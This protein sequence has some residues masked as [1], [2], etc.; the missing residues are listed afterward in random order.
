MTDADSRLTR[1]ALLRRAALSGLGAGLPWPRAA[2]AQPQTRQAPVVIFRRVPATAQFPA[3]G[4]TGPFGEVRVFNLAGAALPVFVSAADGSGVLGLDSSGR[5]TAVR[6]GTDATS[7]TFSSSSVRFGSAGPQP[8]TAD[9]VRRT[10]LE[11]SRDRRKARGAMLLRSALHTAFPVA[12]A[13]SSSAVHK[14]PAEAMAKGVHGHGVA[15]LGCTTRTVTDTVVAQVMQVVNVWKTAEQ[16]YQACVND[17]LTKD[18]CKTTLAVAGG[19]AAGLC[20]AA[21]CGAKSFVDMVTATTE[22]VTTVAE[23]VT[24]EVVTCVAPRPGEWPNPWTLIDHPIQVGLAQA[25]PPPAGGARPAAAPSAKDIEGALKLLP[26]IAGFL[27]PFGTCFFQGHWSLAQLNTPLNIG[28]TGVTLPYGVKCG[29]TAKC[30]SDLSAENVWKAALPSWG[31]A[32]SV[33]ATLS[34]DFATFATPLGI[35]AIPAVAA[36]AASVP[37]AV[38]AA[39]AIILAFVLLA[40]IYGTAISAQLFFQQHFTNNFADGVVYIEHPTFALALIKLATIG[41][42]PAELFPPIVTG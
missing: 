36:I 6:Y 31:A 21:I 28:G 42:A 23:E 29:L 22:V 35:T 30:A 7:I 11:I 38:T 17:Q 5:A 1:R 2:L 26:Q 27:G 9:V 39:A 24:R 10:I 8:W 20:A 13:R 18:P 25:A 4:I 40:L 32:L 16:Q 34:P 14:R 19:V 3:E 37:P 15:A 41:T 12:I 33:L